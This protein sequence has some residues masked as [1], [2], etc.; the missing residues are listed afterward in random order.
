MNTISLTGY[1]GRETKRIAEEMVN[2]NLV[3]FISSDMHHL[4]HAEAFLHALNMP[5]VQKILR[6]N[7]LKNSLLF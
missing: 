3:D 5:Y 2:R 6:S 7:T 4:K 1:Y